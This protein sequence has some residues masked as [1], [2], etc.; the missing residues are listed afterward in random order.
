M[1]TTRPTDPPA[2]HQAPVLETRPE[3]ATRDVEI[4]RG[5]ASTSVK[6]QVPAPKNN[7]LITG[8]PESEKLLPGAQ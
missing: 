7:N 3:P 5:G 6:I 8:G 4:I 1:S 2:T